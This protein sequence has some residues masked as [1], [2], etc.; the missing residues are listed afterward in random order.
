M[1]AALAS[2]SDETL[3]LSPLGRHLAR[4]PVHPRLGKM[5]V[6][7]TLFGCVGPVASV[8]AAVG[9]AGR[10]DA[11]W[12]PDPNRAQQQSR[13]TL[14]APR[15]TKGGFHGHLL[16]FGVGGARSERSQE[17]RIHPWRDLEER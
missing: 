3:A 15:A 10:S 14:A 7:G 5:L 6:Y 8:A 16:T 9:A 2:G 17:P 13:A 11:L 1:E 12:A 4:L